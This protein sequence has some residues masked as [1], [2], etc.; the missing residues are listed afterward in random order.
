NPESLKT[1]RA[2]LEPEVSGPAGSAFQFERIGYFCIDND[3]T[4]SAPILNRTVG[5]RDSWKG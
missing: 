3:S 2:I 1:T 5:L 4:A